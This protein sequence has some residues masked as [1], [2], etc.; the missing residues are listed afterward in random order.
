[1]AFKGGCPQGGSVLLEPVMKVEVVVPEDYMGDIIGNLNSRR[2]RVEGMEDRAGAKVI[3]AM[4]P[5][6]EM[7]AHS[8]TCVPEH[9]AA[10]S[11]LCSL[12][13]TKYPRISRRKSPKNN[14][15]GGK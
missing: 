7:F 6:S 11:L 2:G 10:D 9:R 15:T 8:T 3:H 13:T 12:I 4:V 14:L 5:L 1:M